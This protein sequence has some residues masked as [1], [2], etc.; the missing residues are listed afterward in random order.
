MKSLSFKDGQTFLRI[1]ED[2]YTGVVAAFYSTLEFVDEDNTSLKSIVGSFELQ[3][4]PSDLV[5]I[6]NTPNEGVIC[7]GGSKWWER[8]G[9]TEEEVS[10]V[11]TGRRDYH[12]RDIHTSSLLLNVRAVYSVVQHVVLPRM[13]NTDV[14]FEI[15]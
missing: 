12:V 14:I 8:V 7:R 15:D 3:V 5:S 11:L 2:V 6:T 13:G 10:A 1:S 9:A 4:L